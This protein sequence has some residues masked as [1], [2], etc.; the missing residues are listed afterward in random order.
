M[1]KKHIVIYYEGKNLIETTSTKWGKENS[2][3]FKSKNPTPN[4]VDRYL[5]EHKQFTLIAN[6]DRFVCFKLL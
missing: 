4:E 3:L 6:E 5:V 2:N 1:S